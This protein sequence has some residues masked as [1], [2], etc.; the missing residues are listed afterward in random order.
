MFRLG[1]K[2][3][4]C[5]VVLCAAAACGEGQDAPAIPEKLKAWKS[6]AYTRRYFIKVDAPGEAGNV[7]LH[8]EGAQATVL[9][10]LKVHTENGLR[11]PE[12]IALFSEDGTL[13]RAFLRIV[14]GGSECEVTFATFPGQR[15]FCLY[16]TAMGLQPPDQISPVTPRPAAAD[17]KRAGDLQVRI[18]GASAPPDFVYAPDKPLTLARFIAMEQ[19]AAAA[20]L[21]PGKIQA[22]GEPRPDVQTNIDDPECPFFGIQYSIFD[23][24]NLV[25]NPPNYCALY[26][27]FL[28]APVAGE[29]KFAV[30][31]PGVAHLVINGVPVIAA[32][33]PDEQRKPF[34]QQKSVKLEE[35]VHRVVLHFAEAHPEQGKTNADTRRF[36][37]RLHWQPPFANG[38]M[39]IPPRA[40]IEDLPAVIEAAEKAPGGAT[41]FVHVEVLGHVRAGAHEGDTAAREFVL[42]AMRAT[43]ITAGQRI[44]VK[45]PG[46]E[47]AGEAGQ[48]KFVAWVPA[49]PQLEIAVSGAEAR[50]FSWPTLKTGVKEYIEREVMDLEAELL[51][52]SAPV[53]LYPNES[54]HIHAEAV[55]APKPVIIHKTR[56]DTK[57]VLEP[58]RNTENIPGWEMLPPLPRPMGEF[59]LIA[60]IGSGSPMKFDVTPDVSGRKK[61]L[62]SFDGAKLEK[63]AL[64]KTVPMR[65]RM[66]VDG[67][68]CQEERFRLLDARAKSY[69]G[70][71]AVENGELA[72]RAVNPLAA[73]DKPSES[74]AERMVM[75]VPHVDEASLR[76]MAPLNVLNSSKKGSEALFIGDPLVEGVEAK[77]D[78]AVGLVALLKKEKPELAWKSISIAGPH[79]VRP[80]LRMIA[81]LEALTA[82][83]NSLPRVAVVN[84][85]GGDVARQTQLHTFERALDTLL[86]RLRAGGVSKILLVGPIPEPWREQQCEPYQERVESLITQHGIEGVDIFHQWTRESN[87]PRRFSDGDGAANAVPNNEALQ[88]IAKMIADRVK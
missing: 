12:H 48:K 13:Q 17:G 40:F 35:G 25:V 42:A 16:T 57:F 64:D 52:K 65:F 45:G 54:G 79:R 7:G 47:A 67:I 3:F 88:E 30:D 66:M 31:T 22:S 76:I 2:I 6:A 62:V 81:E 85:G 14:R 60:E 1:F 69:P 63:E 18:R 58:Q 9:L 44:T 74:P 37:V 84:L 4:G 34:A 77:P 59:V 56:F 73:A 86:T 23:K 15:R 50:A 70:K 5:L 53:F 32:D 19:A 36:G 72:F 82:G 41:P 83:G 26:E 20:P 87:W 61:Q 29:Y 71:L 80:V 55:L 78:E 10:P 49:G 68:E 38:L 8:G 39:C 11:R 28:R 43:Q 75:L 21:Q 24:I 51:I 27:G 46:F 33:A